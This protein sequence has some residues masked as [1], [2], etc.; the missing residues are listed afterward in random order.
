MAS[1]QVLVLGLDPRSV[2]GYAPEPVVARI[3]QGRR[4][5]AELGLTEHH[6]L[7]PYDADDA[8]QERRVVA[9][10]GREPW[11]CVVIG[12][13]LRTDEP[14]LGFFERVV[15]LVRQHAPQAAIAFNA[16]AGDSADA[17]RRWI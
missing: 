12:G 6:E 7:L 2:P 4:R 9:A 17:A 1:T 3:E 16:G 10:L 11:A 8:E 13:G 15:N 5:F 14:R